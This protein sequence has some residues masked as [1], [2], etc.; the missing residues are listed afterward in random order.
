MCM[1]LNKIYCMDCFD[2]MG[3]LPDNS[4]DL[5]IADP[6]FGIN[7]ENALWDKD[8]NFRELMI[9]L[10]KEFMRLLK[11]GC[12][13]FCWIPRTELFNIGTYMQDLHLFL[14][15]HP[16]GSH[17]QK[18]EVIPAKRFSPLIVKAKDR[19]RVDIK[20]SRDYIITHAGLTNNKYRVNTENHPS[21]KGLDTTDFI[22]KRYSLENE[23][24]LDPMIGSG[25]ILVSCKKYNRRFIGFEINPE[26]VKIAQNRL[27]NVPTNINEWF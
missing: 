4:I 25:T 23:V 22:V 6:P 13:Y 5:I 3:Q 8:I 18:T 11:T 26:Y 27:D 1:E 12:Y 15:I 14:E 9:K 2:G 24:V 16:T 20:R 10:D 19:P 17:I 7:H 21:V